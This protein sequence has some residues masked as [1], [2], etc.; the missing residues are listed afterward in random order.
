M[1]FQN[2]VCWSAGRVERVMDTEALQPPDDVFLATHHPAPMFRT[3]LTSLYS[4]NRADL[5]SRVLYSESDLLRDFLSPK[6]FAFIPVLGEAGTGKSHLVRWLAAHIPTT[7]TRHVLLIPKVDTNLRDVLARVLAIPGTEGAAFDDYRARLRRATSEL[8]SEREAREKLLNNLAVA[9][10]RNG[11]HQMR[12]LS[13]AQEYLVESLPS[14]LYD[15][16][17]RE[18][19]LRDGGIVHRLVAHAIGDTGRVERLQERREFKGDDLPLRV[20]HSKRASEAARE[21]YSVLLGD[22]GLQQETVKWLNLNLSAA[23]AELLE[24]KGEALFRLMLEVREAL[25]AKGYELVLLIEDFAKL[26]GIDMQ[27]LEAVI[28]KPQQEGRG[29]LCPLR[30]ALACTTGYFRTLV[31]TVQTRV[32]FCVTLDLT[33][34]DA[35]AL[36]PGEIER[37][38]A[39]YLNVARLDEE[40]L[41]RW[42]REARGGG[43]GEAVPVPSACESCPHRADCHDAFGASQ[44]M[45]LYPFTGVAIPKMMA[46]S[47]PEGFNPRL[48]LKDVLKHVLSA[49]AD[50]LRAGTFPPPALAEHFKGLKLPGVVRD[51]LARSDAAT[52]SRRSVLLDLWT[53]GTRLAD[54][55]PGI[56]EAFS[57]PPLGNSAPSQAPV[58][59]QPAAQTP[60]VNE[61]PSGALAEHLALLDAWPG[62]GA[63]PQPLVHELREALFP[64]IREHINWDAELLLRGQFAEATGN[65]PFRQTSITFVRQAVRA[66]Q[67]PAIMLAIPA[68]PTDATA[69]TDASLALQ[70]LLLFRRHGNWKFRHAGRPGSYYFRKYARLLDQWTA[71]VLRQARA[72]RASAEAWDPV[73]AAVEVLALAA[74]MA[75]RPPS[76]RTGLADQISALFEKVD[77]VE[78][79]H[80]GPA[81]QDL[82]KTL[83]EQHQALVTIVKG[84][85]ACTKGNSPAVQVIDASQ[86]AVPLRQ[87]RRTW[88]PAEV[89]PPDAWGEFAPLRKVREKAD[90]LLARAVEEEKARFASW[91][92]AVAG[93]IGQGASRNDL[94]E[95]VRSAA[96]AATSEGV[97]PAG[98]RERLD[99]AMDAFSRCRFDNA[100]Q[101]AQRIRDEADSGVLL[102]EM[103]RADLF[104]PMAA[105]SGFIEAVR[106]FL[107]ASSRRVEQEI[108]Q[109]QGA[110]ELR[111]VQEEIDRS[112]TRLGEHLSLL[113]GEG[114]CSS[115]NAD[116]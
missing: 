16:F 49:Y 6:E 52:R 102:G 67:R 23:I 114:P 92:D 33:P 10:G 110:G 53:D 68:D 93:A 20:E 75:G 26:Q 42:F 25:G 21:F 36:A 57:L 27:L 107:E 50:D 61:A 12:G 81:W 63:V 103:G 99:A 60:A 98:M 41:D 32:D 108:E 22:D 100:M 45:G 78:T 106:Q 18:H 73:P 64:A 59:R 31:Q 39:R 82:M 40:S 65:K 24:L 62:G 43:D 46:R 76:S 89:L 34:A 105:T 116:N 70:G 66:A 101:A 79:G 87:I 56:H 77:G 51:D 111:A 11:P 74:R 71:D 5:T 113:C 83:R 30:T 88:V 69:F 47:S 17:F 80:R 54:L 15:P 4:G 48:L 97:F 14:L 28:A 44:G 9:C 91:L 3:T 95:A 104:T 86:L 109:S 96:E 84:R 94:V 7:A 1:G 115:T 58:E 37:F 90:A 19:L 112:L 2:V 8:R 13:E 55:K 72:S 85:V 29:R 38:V 35:G